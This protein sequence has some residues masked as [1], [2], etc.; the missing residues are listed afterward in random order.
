MKAKVAV[1]MCP[2]WSLETPPLSLGLLAGALKS[3][4][5][6]VKQFHINLLS[7]DY[8][9]QESQEE[10]WAPT[11]HFYW[12]N[13]HSF[14]D[15]IIPAYG[16]YWDTIIEEMAEYDIVTFTTYFSNIVVTD[17]I[18]ERLYNLNPKVHIFYGGAYCWNAPKGGLRQSKPDGEPDRYWIKVSCDTEGELIIN[19]LVERFENGRDYQDV[20]G[21]WTW[22][23][24]GEPLFTGMRIPQKNLD[25]IP[26]AN[27][28]GVD[29]NLYAK[30]HYTDHTHLPI[31]GSRGCTYKCTFC[32]ETRIFRFKK[33]HDIAEEILEQVKKY[34]ITHFSFVDSL[35]N[36]SM[37]QFKILVNEL[38]EEV[39]KNP[40]LKELSLG[41]YARTHD[42]MDMALMKKA[43]KAGFKWL[44]IGVESGT[45]KILEVIEKRQTV[46]QV[47]TLWEACWHN[48]IRMDANWISGYP[49]E[50]HIDWIISLYFLYKNKHYIPVVAA[51]QF[52]AGVTPGTALDQYR[53]VFNITPLGNIFYDWT[54]WDLKNTYI[55]RFLRLKLCHTYLNIHKI[56][57]S[58]FWT[59][60]DDIKHLK[61]KDKHSIFNQQEF[62]DWKPKEKGT[63]WQQT[64]NRR[65]FNKQFE[66]KPIDYNVPYLE[67]MNIPWNDEYDPS[68]SIEDTIKIQ[69]RNEIRVWCWLM[70]Q[71]HGP[72]EIEMI[73]DEDYSERNIDGARMV[74]HFKWN[75]NFD[76]SYELEIDN[77]LTVDK[78]AKK[79]IHIQLPLKYEHSHRRD[80]TNRRTQI[81]KKFKNDKDPVHKDSVH[82]TQTKEEQTLISLYDISFHD[83]YRDLGNLNDR[84]DDEEYLQKKYG[85]PN[86]LDALDVEKYKINLKRTF[87]TGKH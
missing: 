8:V 14:E 68:I 61:F 62:K 38:C 53:D 37:P 22:N 86:Y 29:L 48:G 80:W 3:K 27:W 47:A 54:S 39:D 57:Y 7:A 34:D 40:K 55:N 71:L 18:A 85:V 70:H 51:N 20:S 59:V 32:S 21:I 58:G 56:Y 45:P 74:T 52:P 10:L 6:D 17:Y 76:G 66:I 44:S 2:A 13:D 16:E 49:R 4:G 69:T 15:R 9:D 65:Q 84:Y 87:M 36:G 24:Y 73:F 43:A 64:H 82:I 41:G 42:K 30:F 67:E 33:G 31:Q 12:T 26:K 63:F 72:Y 11:G 77:K 1:V 35:V 79:T 50:N 46:E 78:R 23:D 83:K 81:I 28:D 75:S 5:R 25:N 19:D 60:S